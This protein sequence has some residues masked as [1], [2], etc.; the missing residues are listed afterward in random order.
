[1]KVADIIE[2]LQ[3][4]PPD[5]RVMVDGY[6]SGFEDPHDLVLESVFDHRPGDERGVCE[7]EGRYQSAKFLGKGCGENR[8][9]ALIISRG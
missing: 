4:F 3:S 9:D 2:K 6:E 7:Y 5:M 8:F 1:M